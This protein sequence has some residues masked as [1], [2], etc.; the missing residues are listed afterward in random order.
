MKERV[1]ISENSYGY[2][3]T[4]EKWVTFIDSY[5]KVHAARTNHLFFDDFMHY[6]SYYIGWHPLDHKG[7]ETFPN[8][9]VNGNSF[10]NM[11]QTIDFVRILNEFE[12]E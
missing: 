12:L 8:R 5:N 7:K 10:V 2:L 11:N 9:S 6:Q 3:K 4:P 1:S